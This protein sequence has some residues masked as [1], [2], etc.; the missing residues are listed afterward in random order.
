MKFQL[1]RVI[2]IFSILVRKYKVYADGPKV[3]SYF[4]INLRLFFFSPIISKKLLKFRKPLKPNKTK[5]LDPISSTGNMKF[6]S[7][8]IEFATSS[9][10]ARR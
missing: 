5:K 7:P 1:G 4:F 9:G 2:Q 3:K 8:R 6:S 10:S